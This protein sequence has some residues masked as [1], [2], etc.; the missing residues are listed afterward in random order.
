MLA[1]KLLTLLL[2][3]PFLESC[4]AETQTPTT[5]QSALA[6]NESLIKRAD[7]GEKWAF[8]VDEGILRCTGRSGIG[9]VTFTS[10]Y[11]LNG[12]AANEPQ[13]APINEIWAEDNSEKHRKKDLGAVIEKGFELCR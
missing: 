4:A 2:V 5:N 9:V 11:A 10:H 1:I 7:Y 8:T 13:Y 3:C 12:S 6:A